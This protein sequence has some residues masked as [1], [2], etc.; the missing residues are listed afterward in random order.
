MSVSALLSIVFLQIVSVE[1]VLE[2][3]PVQSL[4]DAADD[5]AFWLNEDNPAESR[6][7]GT[8]KRA[9]LRIYDLNGAEVGFLPVGRVNNVDVIQEVSLADWSG[10]LAAASNRSDDSVS[11]FSVSADKTEMIGGFSV[12]PE[13]YGFCMGEDGG[14]VILFV[15]HKQGYV[16]PYRLETLS[17]PPI[18]LPPLYL[19]TQIEGCVYDQATG[20]FYVGEET[21]GIW[22]V[23]FADG[24]FELDALDLIDATDGDTDLAVYVLGLSIYR[25]DTHHYLVASSQGDNSYHIYDIARDHAFVGKVQIV[26][27]RQ[28][29]IDGAQETDGLDA[30]SAIIPGRFPHGFLIVQDGFNVNG[31]EDDGETPDGEPIV[32]QN[33]KIVDWRDIEAALD[34]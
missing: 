23:P 27:N 3:A 29:G 2:T 30:I 24:R 7:L 12:A 11:L 19:R 14:A 8:D 4:E 28:A 10:D 17:E 6:I 15:A 21:R 9:G 18:A 13:P 22:R 34:Q 20:Q 26:P 1:P 5:P 16:Q 25:S 33:F 32:P 31:I